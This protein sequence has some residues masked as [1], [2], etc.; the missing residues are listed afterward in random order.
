LRI[1]TSGRSLLR[2][3][4]FADP[5]PAGAHRDPLEQ[6]DAKATVTQASDDAHVR[7]QIPDVRPLERR[8]DNQHRQS[9]P[10]VVAPVGPKSCAADFRNDPKRRFS[11][12]KPRALQERPQ[13]TAREVHLV[14]RCARPIPERLFCLASRTVPSLRPVRRQTLRIGKGGRR[15]AVGRPCIPDDPG[16]ILSRARRRR[17]NACGLP[18]R[19]FRLSA[20]FP[21]LRDC[22]VY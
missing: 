1:S 9:A 12:A 5:K 7:R 22:H 21:Q 2:K 6:V 3:Q 14:E 8:R 17:S 13:T 15:G 19:A 4:H 11:L 18:D 20:K 16:R 10:A